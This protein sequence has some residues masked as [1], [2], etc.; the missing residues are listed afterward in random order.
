MALQGP[1]LNGNHV[2]LSDKQ[3]LS[4]ETI[5]HTQTA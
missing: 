3:S 1:S 5:M 4:D 2:F